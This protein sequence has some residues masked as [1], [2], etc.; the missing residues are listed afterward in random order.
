MEVA[1]GIAVII[2]FIALR[3]WVRPKV[4]KGNIERGRADLNKPQENMRQGVADQRGSRGR[5]WFV[6]WW[7]D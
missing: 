7:S 5:S 3:A 6:G 1:I 4:V 2:G